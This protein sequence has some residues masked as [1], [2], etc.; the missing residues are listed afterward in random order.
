M[1]VIYS[2]T[3]KNTRQTAVRDAVDAGTGAGKLKIGTAGMATVIATITLN[4][5][6]GTIASGT[7]T[8]SG[9][10]KTVA[11]SAGGIAAAAVVTDSNDNTVISGLTV[12]TASADII[13]DNTNINAGQ[14]VSINSASF[15][16]G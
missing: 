11:A 5:P 14:N 4:D 13:I 15:P 12:D 9:F 16:H 1:S 3:L 10:P 2:T 8:L 6:C 7:L